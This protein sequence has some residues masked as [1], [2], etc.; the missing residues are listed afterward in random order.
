[1]FA[2]AG[3]SGK[4]GAVTADAL[5]ARG[6]RVRVIVRD[7]AKGAPWAA[8][9]A[10]VAVAD[11]ADRAAVAAALRGVQGAYLLVPPVWGAADPVAAGAELGR[12]LA[13]AAKDAGVPHVVLLSS[14]GA[15]L[16]A[17]NGPI[18]T[19][20]HTE[21]AFRQ[22]GVPTTALRASYFVENW[23]SVAQVVKTDG[24]LPSFI[25]AD[26]PLAQVSTRDIGETAAD[27]LVEGPRGQRVVELRGPSEVTPAQVAAGFGRV[28][29]REIPL[30][31]PPLA[32]A[33]GALVGAGLPQPWAALYA[34][35]YRGLSTGLV[36]SE[37][38]QPQ[39][40]GTTPIEQTLRALV[41]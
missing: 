3:V 6:Q 17:G 35:M 26:Y 5:L 10:E 23:G 7:A 30:V 41:A 39:R 22:A 18:A 28:L 38:G 11:L 24:V 1:M 15:H 16:A 37:V 19:L 25:A 13:S 4:T 36:T 8:K 31:T 40:R 33:E 2:V 27:L 21:A 32:A 20:F 29:G 14:V 9:G 34:E 12:A